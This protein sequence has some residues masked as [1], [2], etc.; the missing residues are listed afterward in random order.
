MLSGWKGKKKGDIN[1]GKQK[2]IKRAAAAASLPFIS[3]EIKNQESHILTL[4]D[5]KIY[6]VVG[7]LSRMGFNSEA[8]WRIKEFDKDSYSSD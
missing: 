8:F 2:Q 5:E 6:T 4:L 3:E 7:S 1:I